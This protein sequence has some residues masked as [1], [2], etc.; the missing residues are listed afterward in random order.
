VYIFILGFC[1]DFVIMMMMAT[2]PS[3]S[4]SSSLMMGGATATLRIET[5]P[6][7]FGRLVVIESDGKEGSILPVRRKRF[8]WGN[9]VSCDYR[10]TQKGSFSSFSSLFSSSSSS[11]SPFF[12]FQLLLPYSCP[13]LFHQNFKIASLPSLQ[14]S[15][16]M[17]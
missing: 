12:S 6:Q 14:P 15:R 11:S 9:D 2:P 3:G 16:L 7:Q 5:P 4:S 10:P 1:I 13:F 17:N 8:R